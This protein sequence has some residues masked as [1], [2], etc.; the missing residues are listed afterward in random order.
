[1]PLTVIPFNEFLIRVNAR[2]SKGNE[3]YGQA[4]ANELHLTRPGLSSRL[5]KTLDP[6]YDD[7]ITPLFLDWV[8]RHW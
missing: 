3:R 8:E 5:P 7:E 1:M 2:M 4:C 6:F